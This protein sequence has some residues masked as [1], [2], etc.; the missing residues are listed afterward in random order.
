[1]PEFTFGSAP[2]HPSESE[3]SYR[4]LTD[5]GSAGRGQISRWTGRPCNLVPGG[6]RFFQR[7]NAD[8]ALY[9]QAGCTYMGG[10][11][12]THS[13]I[14]DEESPF[15]V[16]GST[17]STDAWCCQPHQVI[18]V[19]NAYVQSPEYERKQRWGLIV[20]GAMILGSAYFIIN[21]KKFGGEWS[22]AKRTQALSWGGNPY[23]EDDWD[24]EEGDDE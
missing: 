11:T 13:L 24:T 3:P 5:Y 15:G 12:A 17:T 8:R 9:E 6:Q 2:G 19:F 22:D 16:R 7:D 18:D 23:D 1:M 21:Y 20:V 4:M 10:Q 14:F